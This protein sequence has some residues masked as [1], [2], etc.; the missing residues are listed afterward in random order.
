VEVLAHLNLGRSREGKSCLIQQEK[1][2]KGHYIGK[3]SIKEQHILYIQLS[4][5][6]GV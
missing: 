6:S 1:E 2:Q 4:F 5:G 3:Y